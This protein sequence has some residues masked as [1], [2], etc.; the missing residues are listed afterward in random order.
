MLFPENGGPT[1]ERLHASALKLARQFGWQETKPL[2]EYVR[3]NP[4]LGPKIKFF[5][6]MSIHIKKFRAKGKEL[7]G[8]IQEGNK[9]AA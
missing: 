7:L 5:I 3:N 1:Q 6:E 9:A 2:E 8:V 4:N